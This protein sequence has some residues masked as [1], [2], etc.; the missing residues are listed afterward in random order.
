MRKFLLFVFLLPAIQLAA[1]LQES[2]YPYNAY[3]DEAYQ[4]YPDI[5]RGVLEAVSYTNTHIRHINPLA[6]EASCAGLP[7]FYGVMGLVLDGKGYFRENLKTVAN[8]SGE[9]VNDII[10]SPRTNILA[11]AAAYHNLLGLQKNKNDL[12]LS[13]SKVLISLSELN[14]TNTSA[15]NDYTMNLY[16]YGIFYFLNDKANHEKYGFPEYS[17]DM[18]GFFGEANMKVFTAKQVNISGGEVSN[19]E[20]QIYAPVYLSGPCPDYVQPNCTWVESPNHYT[21]WNGHTIS[22]IAIHT[23]QGSYTSCINWFQ[24]TEAN[25]ATHYVVAS[26]SSYAGQ[27][28]QMVNEDNAGWHVTTE[29]WY[30]IGYEHEGWVDD[31]SWYTTTMYQTSAALTR[32]ICTRQN[33]NPLRTFFREVLDDGTVLDDGLHSLGAEGSCIKIKGH[34]HFPNQTHTDPGLNWNWDYYY[35]LINNTTPVTT[36]T[37]ASGSFYDTGGASASYGNDERKF[38]LIQPENAQTVTLTFSQFA[39]EANYDFLYIYD[40]DNEFAPLIGR[41]N[42]ICPTTVTSTGGSLFI[43]FRSD[44]A[45]V[46]TGWAATWSSVLLDLVAPT[47][48][49]SVGGNWQTQNFTATFTDADN[50]GGSG[51]EKS[52][53]QVLDYNGTEWHANAQN[54]FFADNFDSYNASVWTVPASAGT[55]AVTAGSLIQSDTTVS[56]TNIYAAL[57]QNLSNRYIYQ[58]YVKLDDAS[59]GTNQH[60]FG[61][62]FFSDNASLSNRGNSYFIFFRQESSKLEFYKVV[63]DTFTQTKVVD[64]VITAFDQWYD[65]KVI[66][67]RITGKTDVYRDNV[68]LG[69]WTDPS[70][71]TTTGSYVSFRTGN[72]KA[73][74]SELKVYRSR[75]PSVTISVGAAGTNDIRYQNP[76]PAT[77]AAK[78]KS[79]VNDAAGNLSTIDYYNLNIDW[80][81]PVCNT[82]NDGTGADISTTTSATTLS[83]NWEA[84]SDPNSGIAKYWYAIGTTPGGTDV[85]GWTDNALTTTVTKSGL[86]LTDGQ[87]YYFSIKTENGAGLINICN[88]NGVQA[89][90]AT[91]VEGNDDTRII[92]LYPNPFSESTSLN[93]YSSRDQRVTIMLTDMLGRKILVADKNVAAGN[94]D[95]TI[96]SDELKLSKG[97]YTLT[98]YSDQPQRTAVS[99]RMV[100]Y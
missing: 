66:F 83:A 32:D 40:G 52:F 91:D 33:I 21:G 61:F 34:Q 8:L 69:T 35:K 7:G 38:W 81:I 36:Y 94:H 59:S 4:L 56:N 71:L 6:E 39:V 82:V 48:I 78:I 60:R 28:T 1:Q 2:S 95:I 18:A 15:V 62:H 98:L 23:V 67:D 80:T 76:D 12:A 50:T 20:G 63:N 53:Y 46:G 72:C 11:Y 93:F 54:G 99:V 70:P 3:F 37:T 64:G 9:S 5:P 17:I 24:N 27:V 92:S 88:S 90:L 65:L 30:A 84:S 29:N 55:W 42:T 89:N 45:T 19:N 58:F 13:I 96:N 85:V 86:S 31:P 79:I 97:V 87:M 100:R 74:I 49:T 10:T 68:L 26:N 51:I 57:N 14:I 16:L 22:A 44:C 43:E 41:Y 77:Y 75:Y 47:T 73:Y 25:A